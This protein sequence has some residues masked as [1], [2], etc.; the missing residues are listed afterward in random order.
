MSSVKKLESSQKYHFL[1]EVTSDIQAKECSSPA[2][3]PITPIYHFVTIEQLSVSENT[4]LFTYFFLLPSTKDI[5]FTS[6]LYS[7]RMN[8]KLKLDL[9]EFFF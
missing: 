4:L 7:T 5:Y 1:R 2:N 8:N 9:L 3:L 6:K